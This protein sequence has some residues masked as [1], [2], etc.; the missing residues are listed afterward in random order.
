MLIFRCVPVHA[1]WDTTVKGA[2][3]N[4]DSKKFFFSTIIVHLLMDVAILVLPVVE[5]SKLHV[6][7][8]QKFALIGFF[9]LG[10]MLV[11]PS[12]PWPLIT[13]CAIVEYV[14]HQPFRW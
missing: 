8:Y 14:L 3:C 2:K 6:N 1:I 12:V 13:N 10:I 11:F 5:V 7:L 9:V 4:I